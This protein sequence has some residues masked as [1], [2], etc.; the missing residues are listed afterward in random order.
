MHKI[1]KSFA[2]PPILELY[3]IISN[4]SAAQDTRLRFEFSRVAAAPR[5]WL[6]R[7][8]ALKNYDAFPQPIA[9]GVWE[10]RLEVLGSTQPLEITNGLSRD[11]AVE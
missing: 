4:G 3:V 9:S 11:R 1:E 2:E 10:L 6:V 5:I 8:P 7:L